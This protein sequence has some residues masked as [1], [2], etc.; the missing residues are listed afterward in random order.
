MNNKRSIC[1]IF[2]GRFPSEKAASLFVAKNAEAFGNHG[3]QVTLLVPRR[4]GRMLCDPYEQ[5]GVTKNFRVVYLPIIDIFMVPFLGRIA[6]FVSLL[7][8]SLSVVAYALYTGT[9]KTMFYSNE[10]IPLYVLSFLFKHTFY[11]MHDFPEKKMSRVFY[12]YFLRRM[13]W[14]LIHNQWK[15][16]EARKQFDLQKEKLLLQMNAVDINEFDIR[17]TKREAREKLGLSLQ[18]R[19]GVYTG[20]LYG[21]KGVHT[22]ADSVK[23]LDEHV[24]VFFVG[25]TE[26]DIE[27]FR[28]KYQHMPQIV[29]TG[30]KPHSEISVWQKAADVLVIPNTAKEKISKYYTSPMKLFEYMASSRPIV[31]TDIPSIREIIGPDEAFICQPDDAQS[32]ADAIMS[33]LLHEEKSLRKAQMALQK[34]QEYTWDKRAQNILKFANIASI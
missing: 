11:E 15:L 3:H 24:R 17:L 31:A 5:Y 26:N 34:V 19:V 12:S 27:A 18:E 6:F 8:F 16:D 2:H 28:E 10:N 32:M 33:A 1:L 23:F 25:G 13:K 4:V 9:N 7:T 30:H 20:H 22:L 14:I 21:W 29:I